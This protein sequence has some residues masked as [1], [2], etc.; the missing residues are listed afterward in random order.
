MSTYSSPY[1]FHVHSSLKAKISTNSS[2]FLSKHSFLQCL[3]MITFVE[4][5]VMVTI[6]LR[7]IQTVSSCNAVMKKFS[8]KLHPVMNFLKQE[9]K[10]HRIDSGSP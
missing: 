4:A 7:S 1:G 8:Q 5:I 10:Q 6:L 9:G 2:S 3:T